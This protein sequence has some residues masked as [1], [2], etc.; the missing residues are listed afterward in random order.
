M[1]QGDD[2]DGKLQVWKMRSH[3]FGAVSSSSVASFALSCCAE[4][5]RSRYPEAADVL[6]RKTYVDDALCATDS[7]ESAVQL[8]RVM[9]G[10]RLQHD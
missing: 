4:E 8:E 1:V 5:G 6:L 3:V 10:W 9:S 2:P 7:V